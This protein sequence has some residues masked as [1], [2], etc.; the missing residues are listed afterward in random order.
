MCGAVVGL[1]RPLDPILVF[2]RL[3]RVS[4][5]RLVIEDLDV[6]GDRA[7]VGVLRPPDHLCEW[8]L[9]GHLPAFNTQLTKSFPKADVQVITK[10]DDFAE[11]KESQVLQVC[12]SAI[13]INGSL[14]KVLK[15]K[16]DRRNASAHPSG[17]AITQLTAEEFIRDL[18]DNVVLKLT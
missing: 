15:E 14:H 10:R 12:K 13:I 1:V 9:A 5:P 3:L 2:D 7:V 6:D 17:I 8:V 4:A 16:L 18:V 11:L